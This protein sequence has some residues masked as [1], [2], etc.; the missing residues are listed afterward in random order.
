MIINV[1]G[2]GDTAKE[3][4]PDGN[5][6]LCVNDTNR[7]C[8]YRVIVDRFSAFS[9]GRQFALMYNLVERTSK[10]VFS[11]LPE[12]DILKDK[13]FTHINLKAIHAH[14]NRWNEFIP[15][16]NNSPFVAC[17][18]AYKYFNATEIRLWGVDMLD[19]PHLN[20]AMR[21]QSVKDFKLLQK[22][23]NEKGRRIIP[24]EKSYLYGKI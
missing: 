16:S 10:G 13:N 14:N 3:F 20:G 22:I 24:H 11:Q 6:T 2:L 17:G 5:L 15:S 21:E 1:I 7:L 12:W 19:H 4:N 8:D 9:K 18:V 23:L